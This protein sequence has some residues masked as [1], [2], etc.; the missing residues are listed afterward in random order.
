[1]SS[2]SSSPLPWNI[3]ASPFVSVLGTNYVP[4]SAEIAQLKAVL[5]E[6]QQELLRLESEI[7]RVQAVLDTLL[8][9]RSRVEAYI[10]AH[11]ALIS[12]IRQIP[13]ET[14]AEIFKWCLPS[15]T[16]YG[17]RSLQHA[18]LLLTMVCRDWRR[19][20]I[21]TPRLWSSLHIYFPP[22]LSQDAASQRIAGINS[23]LQ[24][25]GSLPVFISLDGGSAVRRLR[26][27][28]QQ[29]SGSMESLLKTVLYFRDR[30]QNLNLV[31]NRTDQM[32]FHESLPSGSSFPYLVSLVL[33]DL[34]SPMI[35]DERVQYHTALLAK[36]PM[37]RS[38]DIETLKG[39]EHISYHTLSCRWDMLTDLAIRDILTPS[40]L[41]GVLA[42][43]SMLKTFKAGVTISVQ[44][45]DHSALPTAILADLAVLHL[46]I[47][48][49]SVPG[50][51]SMER[52]EV[53]HQQVNHLA[54]I[55]AVVSRIVCPSLKSLHFCL[56]GALMVSSQVPI[57]N[58]PLHNLESLGLDIPLTPEA[59]AECLSLVPNL[60]SLD[61]VDAGNIFRRQ[62]TSTLEDSYLTSL[63]PSASNPLP[64]CPHLRH[65]RMI[66]PTPNSGW[67]RRWSTQVLTEFIVV[68]H[69]ARMLDSCELIFFKPVSFADEEVRSLRKAKEDGLELH[70]QTRKNDVQYTDGP[71]TGLVSAATS[72]NWA[73]TL[74]NM[75]LN[76]TET[77]I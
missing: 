14:L 24:R 69:K 12:P 42:G 29:E 7:T 30:M 28:N 8:S 21:E 15:D 77:I 44:N 11:Q 35:V 3:A 33:K 50:I 60:T 67:S 1:M 37:L 66:D 22:H 45:F 73:L 13:N 9:E 58:F 74:F 41:L 17:L 64:L 48:T 56:F 27:D 4:F 59:F 47:S 2:V 72:M 46:R 18:P 76:G 36:M 63:I 26:L 51:S 39:R 71:M 43:C 52:E 57:L 49:V 5:I 20:A 32:T 70:A 40:D 68:R 6:P 62:G 61:F 75:H 16:I 54:H 38:L 31:L 25:S 23:W 10:D 34:R 53:E 19:V 55:S 65:L